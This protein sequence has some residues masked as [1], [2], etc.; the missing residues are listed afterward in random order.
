MIFSSWALRDFSKSSCFFSSASTLSRESP[1]SS[2]SRKACTIHTKT[3]WILIPVW[4]WK[5]V[6]V[7][8]ESCG[9]SAHLLF[10]H[11]VVHLLSV[12]VEELQVHALFVLLPPHLP[13]VQQRLLLIGEDTQL[14]THQYTMNVDIMAAY[15]QQ[16]NFMKW[17]VKWRSLEAIPPFP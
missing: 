7:D 8:S 2:F 3:K 12:P 13:Q 11:P 10:T 14:Q 4:P 5:A 6:S 16:F 15:W 1:R 9:V 17:V